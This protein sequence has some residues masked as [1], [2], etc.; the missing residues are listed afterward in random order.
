M[1]EFLDD[2][3]YLENRL[4]MLVFPNLPPPPRPEEWHPTAL[5]TIQLSGHLLS[6]G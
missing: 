1:V 6:P 3:Q 4:T 5:L 2:S